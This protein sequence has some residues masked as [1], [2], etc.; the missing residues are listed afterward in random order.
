MKKAI[1]ILFT[2]ISLFIYSQQ[3]VFEKTLGQENVETLNS[4]IENFET[5]TLKKEYANLTTK[6]SYKKFLKDNYSIDNS[7]DKRKT[8]VES[9][10]KLNIYCVPD[11]IWIKKGTLSSGKKSDMIE[12]RYKCLKQNNEVIYSKSIS[13]CCS[14]RNKTVNLLEQNKGRV[15]INMI[16]SYIKALEKISNKS[17][18]LNF[19]LEHI[20][21][22]ATPMLPPL[23]ANY[24]LKNNI[25]TNDYFVKRIIY[26][27]QIYR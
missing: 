16:G 24:I 14:D 11:S 23:M 10:L 7:I 4:L 22:T 8:F 17:N 26:I 20:K 13:H 6:N 9:K 3:T 25:N 2:F 15:Q 18:F 27:N 21:M 12:T 5:K 19:Y 1:F